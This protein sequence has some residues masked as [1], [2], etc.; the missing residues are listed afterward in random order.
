MTSWCDCRP[1]IGLIAARSVFIIEGKPQPHG[2]AMNTQRLHLVILL[3][4][5]LAAAPAGA[6]DFRTL[7][8]GVSEQGREQHNDYSLKL[9]FFESGGPYLAN[10]KTQITDGRGNILMEQTADGPWL[11]VDLPPGEYRVI[12]ERSNGQRQGTRFQ[13]EDGDQRQIALAFPKE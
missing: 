3:L 10:I 1:R 7:S 11:F 8:A 5:P 6:A 9:V 12:A 2:A 4:T 13:I